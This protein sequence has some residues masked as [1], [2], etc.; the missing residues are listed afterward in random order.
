MTVVDLKNKV[1]VNQTAVQAF[2]DEVKSLASTPVIQEAKILM[3]VEDRLLRRNDAI[4]FDVEESNTPVQS[5]RDVGDLGEAKSICSSLNIPAT[6][7]KCFRTCKYSSVLIKPRLLKV[8]LNNPSSV[9]QLIN[10]IM[11]IKR[12]TAQDTILHRILI[13]KYRTEY[14]RADHKKIKAELESRQAEGETDLRLGMSNGCCNI[15]K[16]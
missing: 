14:Q 2:N 10:N 12:G 4:I 15:I 1:S 16:S 3:E 5:I 7:C 8:I 6:D 9:D 11:K 13:F